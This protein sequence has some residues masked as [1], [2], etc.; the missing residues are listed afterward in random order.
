[1][2]VVEAWLVVDGEAAA[3]AT[4][5]RVWDH[6]GPSAPPPRLS[7]PSPEEAPR[8]P[9][10]SYFDAGHPFETRVVSRGGREGGPGVFWSRFNS[11]L[12][13]GETASPVVRACMSADVTTGLAMPISSRAWK[14][15]N[16]DLSIYF[17][18]D[19]VGDWLLAASQVDMAAHG[20]GLTR[21]TL[22]DE[23][24][25]FGYGR[26]SLVISRQK[27]PA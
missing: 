3:K 10:V 26:Q 15:P 17:A 5:L 24:G 8:T 18:R 14:Y 2:Q 4:G 23:T 19:P 27:V 12:I 9:I 11:Q 6:D 7:Y 25:V 1:M 13:A 20:V 16:A 21:T 22:A